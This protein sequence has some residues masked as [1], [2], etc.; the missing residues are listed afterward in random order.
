MVGDGQQSSTRD[1]RLGVP[2]EY[3]LGML[4]KIGSYQGAGDFVPAFRCYYAWVIPAKLEMGFM[5][6]LA[7]NGQTL[8]L[9]CFPF[10]LSSLI[11]PAMPQAGNYLL[12]Y[13]VSD[14]KERRAVMDVAQGFGFRVQKSAFE[15]LLKRGQRER[16]KQK[17]ESLTLTTGWVHLYRVAANAQRWTV[18]AE[19]VHQPEK[20]HEDFVYLL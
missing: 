19:P 7:V 5:G 6:F 18:G 8:P 4:R 20:E 3:E 1:L 17:L 2:R 10:H 13:D 9:F 16:L 15:C 12:I 14:D 11:I